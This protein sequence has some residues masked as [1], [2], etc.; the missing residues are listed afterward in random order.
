MMSGSAQRALG[1]SY[2]AM[3][4]Q[5]AAKRRLAAR[6]DVRDGAEL[7]PDAERKRKERERK[8]RYR[9]RI[10]REREHAQSSEDGAGSQTKSEAGG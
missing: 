8:R 9:Q 6:N 2:A 3:A 7:D 4:A 10:K 5:Q 1:M